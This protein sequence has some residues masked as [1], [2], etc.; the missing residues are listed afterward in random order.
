MGKDNELR[1][2]PA[3]TYEALLKAQ[4]FPQQDLDKRKIRNRFQTVFI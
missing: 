3:S 4:F 2:I 1:Q